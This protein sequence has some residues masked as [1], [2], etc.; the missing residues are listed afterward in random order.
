MAANNICLAFNDKHITH[1][2]KF[3]MICKYM[4]SLAKAEKT[5]VLLHQICCYRNGIST[6]NTTSR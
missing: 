1:K 2:E 5:V 4:K 3:I 6:G